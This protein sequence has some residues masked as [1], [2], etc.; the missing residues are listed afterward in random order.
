MS[1][2]SWPKIFF[3]NRLELEH[4]ASHPDS[5]FKVNWTDNSAWFRLKAKFFVIELES[6]FWH[7]K[8][9]KKLSFRRSCRHAW[10]SGLFYGA[11]RSHLQVI[12]KRRKMTPLDIQFSFFF[13][14][15]YFLNLKQTDNRASD[16]GCSMYLHCSSDVMDFR[17]FEATLL[18]TSNILS[19][20]YPSCPISTSE[21]QIGDTTPSG[22]DK[23]WKT[24]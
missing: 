14:N 2:L 15:R 18:G 8:C 9:F 10:W 16:D 11:P 3:I 19:N 21:G 7:W 1:E 20:V 5:R 24:P 17:F 22:V 13:G 23:M 4:V 6:N 12:S